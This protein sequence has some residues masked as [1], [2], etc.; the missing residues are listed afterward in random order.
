MVIT[1]FRSEHTNKHSYQHHRQGDI[2]K[3]GMHRP[4]A[5]VYLIKHGRMRIYRITYNTYC[6]YDY[7]LKK[8]KNV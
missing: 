5:H 4:A 3:P 8:G 7:N 2:K 6:Y 1:S